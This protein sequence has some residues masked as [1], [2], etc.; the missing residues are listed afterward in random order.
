MGIAVLGPLQVDGQANGLSPRD[1]VVLSALVARAGEPVTT[2]ALADALWGE[3]LPPTWSKVLQGCVVRLRKQL[4]GGA[5]VS[6]AHGYRLALTDEELDHKVFE[7]LL[8]RAREALAAD[9]PARASYLAQDALQLWRG[10]A[11]PDLQ[12]W[13]PGRVETVRL[14]GLRMDAEELLVEAETAAGRARDV[15]ERARALVAQAPFRE[16]R[17]ALLA[18]ALHQAGRQPEAL[19]AI[20]RARAM[21]AE[22][23][24]LDPGRELVELEALL[25]R[26][27]PSLSPATSREISATCPYR[28]LLPYDAADADTYFGREDDIAA[29]QR[30]LRDTG[31]LTVIG[32]SGVGKSS[33]VRAG[34]VA[35][36]IRS[37]TPVL[38]TSPG[39]HPMDSIVGLKPRGRQTL[40][41]D[42]AEEAVTLCTGLAERSRYF[43]ALALHVGA[44]GALVLALRAD[45]LGD[46]APYPEIARV[47]EDG[48]YLLGPMSE[49]GLRSAIEGPARRAGLR[50]EPGLVDL[51]VREVEGEPAALPLLSHVL[52]E[53]WERR[54]GPTLTVAG[55]RATGGIRQ[56]VS[57]SAESL[58]D[59]MDATQRAHLRSL[60]LRLVMPTE[61]GDPVRARVPRA[62]VAVDVAHAR[63]LEQ[64]VEARLVSVDGDTLQIAHEALVR[65]WPRLRGWLDDDLDGQRLF[66]HLAGA[67]DAWQAMG[68][69]DSELYRGT[70]LT[71]SLE[72][73]DRSAP[74]LTDSETAFLDASVELATAEQQA[75][76]TQIARERRSRR[77]LRGALAGVGVLLVLALVAGVLAIRAANEAERDRERHEAAALLAEARRAGAQAAAQENIAT[78]LLLAV[79]ALNV[80]SSP[81]AWDNLAAALTRAGPL[82]RVGNVGGTTVSMSLSPDGEL[83]AVGMPTHQT[84]LFDTRT[85]ERLPFEDET[86]PASIVG[87]S[88]DGRQLAVAVNQ[89]T[90]DRQAPPRIDRQP[91]RLYDMPSGRLSDVQLGGFRMGD[92]INYALDFSDDGMRI[93]TVVQHYDRHT[94]EFTKLGAGTVW[95][96]VHRAGPIFRAPMPESGEVA[97]SRDG[98][99]LYA[100]AKGPRP[101]RVYDVDSGRL[102]AAAR[103]RFVAERGGGL[104]LSP[105]GSTIAV[106]AGDRVLRFD[107]DTLRPTGSTIRGPG[108][109]SAVYSHDGRF[110]ASVT[111]D[112]AIVLDAGTGRLL[113]R[114]APHNGD[115]FT[116]QWSAD[117]RALYTTSGVDVAEDDL[118]MAW[119]VDN[120]PGLL[121]LGEDTGPPPGTGYDFSAPAPGGRTLAR[122]QAHRLRFVNRRTGRQTP[123][124]TELP[125]LWG[126]R[127]SPD[128]RRFLTWSSDTIRVWD[129]ESGRQLA[130][131]PHYTDLLPVAFS[132]DGTRIYLPDGSGRLETLDTDTLR[133][134]HPAVALGSGV[135]SL[136][137][138]PSDGT[139][140]ALRTDGSVVRMEPSTGEVLTEAPPGTL[141]AQAQTW[142]SSPD[143]S[144]VATADLTGGMRLMDA[145]SLTW[146]G[147]DSGAP[148]GDDRDYAPDGTQI[149]AVNGDR[150]S[151]WDGD[152]GAYAASLPLPANAGPVSI[153]YLADSSGLV[154]GA[155]DGRT[156]TA[157][158]RTDT[159]TERACAIAGRNLTRG[160]WTRFFPSRPYA[161]TCPRW[162][163]GG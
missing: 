82:L 95:D 73:R 34:V 127:W 66:R 145:T 59:A 2:E 14:E 4:G 9:D 33:L 55:Y 108:L 80:D 16:A 109:A 114:F 77:R 74:D 24:G 69:P 79:E 150:I 136:L 110:L 142:L 62:K 58:Y 30:R 134:V 92:S 132:P 159:W 45:H 121:T 102:L 21:L 44:G 97:L 104:E 138:N 83:V 93:A 38:V 158:T 98:T 146:V 103:N 67:A 29:C 64:L 120:V 23:F 130:R 68:R 160:E 126:A 91:L 78:G 154:I 17:W 117:D 133:P 54:E 137:A 10:Q 163:A 135:R 139:V 72:W 148:W 27:D 157:D 147:P 111:G 123:R 94:G 124:S 56:A 8:T 153:A 89:W 46:L 19:A 22:E 42:Q 12:E 151:L 131:R 13:E 65:V 129:A 57:R 15:L 37:G 81:Q 20:K 61:D 143:G 70:R 113:H 40:V 119:R 31:V 125:D 149:A 11:L 152:T 162:P 28:G 100:A 53:T 26:Q 6:A 112:S 75:A 71:R 76:E 1:R 116:A 60:L 63:L 50:L 140:L 85:F 87:F 41:V 101:V 43:A 52:R 86:P 118:L 96:L 155:A 144:V 115:L 84:R 35:S 3:E 141:T 36:L 156:W 7:R 90:P 88:P 32:P 49:P 161:T 39:M 18:R 106:I 48:L 107:A 5:I 122:M 47:L 105:D 51:L 25:L 99:R 128:S